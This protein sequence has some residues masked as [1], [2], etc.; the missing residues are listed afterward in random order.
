MRPGTIRRM[1]WI[2]A[3]LIGLMAGYGAVEGRSTGL[4][5][6]GLALVVL[7]ILYVRQGRLPDIGLLFIGMGAIPAVLLGTLLLDSLRDPAVQPESSTLPLFG[8]AVLLIVAGA[9]IFVV[10][11][12]R[13]SRGST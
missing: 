13:G 1:S 9:A 4:L 7:P 3:L 10:S 6:A 8:L 12:A 5:V 11:M 2:L